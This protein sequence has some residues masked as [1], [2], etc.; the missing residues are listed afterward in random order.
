MR[1]DAL[2]VADAAREVRG[3][4]QRGV[5]V[6][7]E[8]APHGWPRAR[9]I[10]VGSAAAV[11][12]HEAAGLPSLVRLA[13]PGSV[14]IPGLVNAHTHLDLTHIGP[15]PHDPEAGF[16]PWI[17]MI[18]RHR[19][20]TREEI[21]ASVSLGASLSLRAGVVAGGDI[22]GGVGG[23]AGL[24]GDEALAATGLAG[25]SFMEFFALGA[26]EERGLA[27]VREAIGRAEARG[28]F[29]QPPPRVRF[30]IQPHSP[31]SVG[32]AAFIAAA[33]MLA[34]RGPMCTH[35]A[36]SA[37]ERALV[38]GASGPLRRMLEGFGLWTDN[39]DRVFGRPV[40]PVEHVR[41]CALG[42]VSLFAHVN[43]ARDADLGL[44]ADAGASVAYCPRASAYFGAERH[45]GAHR[46]REMLQ[47]GVNVALGTDSIV[48]LPADA[49][50]SGMSI[51]DEMRFLHRYDGT[52]A[53]MLLEM[54]TL[55][56]ARALGL[57]EEAFEIC[58][59]A[60]I[61]G[62]VCVPIE[63]GPG[64]GRSLA[65]AAIRSGAP[66]ELL[67]HDRSPPAA[68]GWDASA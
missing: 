60:T 14:L 24:S 39:L 63:D 23:R 6:L 10:A 19:L 30:G 54:G 25:V 29:R 11:D 67:V 27:G 15:R 40:S 65:E 28:L 66:P 5:S 32:P 21:A 53:R 37:E 45:F 9:V 47:S 44:L 49:P 48:N 22:A 41:D 31:Y 26:G 1:I 18:R 43:D 52:D 42:R 61:A 3:E 62:V 56:G 7:I 13:R 33:E 55:N 35:L 50:T 2:G 38:E 34:G 51:L 12:G 58:E 57:P 4:G 20:G 46:F 64:G 16:V 68:R 17:E 59:G 8:L 36:E